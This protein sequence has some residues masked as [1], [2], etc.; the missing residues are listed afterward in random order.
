M[1]IRTA[2]GVK[3]LFRD[4]WRP[5]RPLARAGDSELPPNSCADR[6]PQAALRSVRAATSKPRHAPPHRRRF[7][8]GQVADEHQQTERREARNQR[9]RQPHR[10][11]RPKQAAAAGGPR[12]SELTPSQKEV[13]REARIII[14]RSFVQEMEQ[15]LA[16]FCGR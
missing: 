7:D 16:V 11:G 3:H 2:R 8:E 10:H 15:V 9:Q 1:I 6:S 4:A 12:S 5:T 13:E 14:S